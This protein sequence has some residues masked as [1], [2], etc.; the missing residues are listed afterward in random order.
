LL[1]N[2]LVIG[3]NTTES[4]LHAADAIVPLARSLV[5][6]LFWRQLQQ[7]TLPEL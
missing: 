2:A 4:E 6:L 7:S 3:W 1:I 5:E